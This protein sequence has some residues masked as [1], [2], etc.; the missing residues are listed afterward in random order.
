MV[1]ARIA[2]AAA[3]ASLLVSACSA[4]ANPG[5]PIPNLAPRNAAKAAPRAKS[6]ASVVMSVF[7]PARRSHAHPGVVAPHFISPSTSLIDTTVYPAGD[8][9]QAS[10]SSVSVGYGSSVCTAVPGGRTCTFSIPAPPGNDDF[11]FDT[12]DGPFGKNGPPSSTL[13]ES[14][15]TPAT[16]VENTVNSV[17]ASVGG[18]IS[19]IGSSVPFA[20]L[21]ADG[22]QR[23]FTFALKPA[24]A[25]GNVI[26]A[27]AGNPY[28]NPIT[29]KLTEHGGSGHAS[30]LLTHAGGQPVNDGNTASVGYSTDT[31]QLRYDGGGSPGYYASI[32]LSAAAYQTQTV[33]PQ[34]VVV[35][36]L[37]VTSASPAYSLPPPALRFTSGGSKATLTVSEA[38]RPSATFRVSASGCTA[39]ATDSISPASP[40]SAT[41]VVTAAA[42]PSKTCTTM[43]LAIKDNLGTVFTLPATLTTTGVPIVVPSPNI[44]IIPIA[45][46]AVPVSIA[47]GADGNMW[48]ADY[49]R[50]VI[51]RVSVPALTVTEGSLAKNMLPFS[52][53]TGPDGQMW[54]AAIPVYSGLGQIGRITESL[55]P[56]PVPMPAGST[57]APVGLTVGPDGNVWAASSKEAAS[58]TPGGSFEFFPIAGVTQLGSIATA[59]GSLWLAQQKPG[60]I[61]ELTTAGA[62][63]V[64]KL[65]AGL[66]A[67][68][69]TR[70][71]D[72][73]PWIT[74]GPNFLPSTTSYIATVG[75]AGLV[76]YAIPWATFEPAG[77]VS[78]P[79]GA[80]WFA[81]LAAQ[82]IGRFDPRTKQFTEYPASGAPLAIAVGTDG[83][84]WFSTSGGPTGNI[85]RLT[86]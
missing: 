76:K 34:T 12:L 1:N 23:L 67:D 40:T 35:S 53:V 31:L 37:Y 30:L 71:P 7:I 69:L 55:V 28:F 61:V 78:G 73:N 60:L 45:K 64:T 59:N 77:I 5:A 32:V 74:A 29:A 47:A 65:P 11:V 70:G 16:I 3:A 79:D 54:Y 82:A 75:S 62:V 81:D 86:P 17:N 20:T 49:N 85:C 50:S 14:P 42:A 80:L 48:Y 26:A 4:T 21:P 51:G 58:I 39:I 41:L 24:D 13:G 44:T 36:P 9:S 8:P 57:L 38:G 72:G 68:G 63:T 43:S 27:P 19:T 52:I 46:N 83:A 56:E 33:V 84:I 22:T 66:Y 18:I 10:E 2:A 6:R 25:D 15:V